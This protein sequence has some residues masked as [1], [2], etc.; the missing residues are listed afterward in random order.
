MLFLLRAVLLLGVT[1]SASLERSDLR[2]WFGSPE[3]DAC[4]TPFAQ[5]TSKYNEDGC[6]LQLADG[7]AVVPFDESDPRAV[8]VAG[9]RNAM[10]VK[11]KTDFTYETSTTRTHTAL[12]LHLNTESSDPATLC[13]QATV[14][15]TAYKDGLRDVAITE[16]RDPDR[17]ITERT[18]HAGELGNTFVVR[19]YATR[20]VGSPPHPRLRMHLIPL[21]VTQTERNDCDDPDGTAVVVSTSTTSPSNEP[22]ESATA[23]ETPICR[24]GQNVTVTRLEPIVFS[25]AVRTDERL[26]PLRPPTVDNCWRA[27]DLD[28]EEDTHGKSEFGTSS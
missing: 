12:A 7:G 25:V 27:Y 26:A 11:T 9:G 22:E 19:P 23:T 5:T 18:I 8:F 13:S 17:S 4:Y 20:L 6:G 14:T 10:F 16:A 21:L 1:A 3:R 2:I 15:R 28:H 24:Y